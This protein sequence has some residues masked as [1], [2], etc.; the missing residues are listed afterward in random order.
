MENFPSINNPAKNRAIKETGAELIE[1][2]QTF[3]ETAET[4]DKLCIEHGL[5]YISLYS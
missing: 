5:Y 1:A 4:V 3:E 2:G